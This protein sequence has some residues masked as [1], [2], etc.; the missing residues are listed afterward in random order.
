MLP[1]LFICLQE[2]RGFPTTKA[3]LQPPNTYITCST[4]GKLT[5]NLITEWLDKVFLNEVEKTEEKKALLLHDSTPLFKNLEPTIA[6]HPG[7][8]IQMAC[9]PP[10]TTGLVQPL[11]VF[12]FRPWKVFV[13][14]ISDYVIFHDIP[15]SLM[16]RDNVIK[17][18]SL[19]HYQFSAERYESMV[20]YSFNKC[21]FNEQYDGEEFE[22]P[23]SFTFGTGATL[24]DC[25]SCISKGKEETG[26]GCCGHC[27]NTFCFEHFYG[28]DCTLD[29]HT[30][31]DGPFT[32]V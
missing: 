3:F 22:T 1:I 15:I 32:F 29:F 18:Q 25:L 19:V 13:R 2:P 6:A 8:N 26:F 12:F 16:K 24:S 31:L 17:L 28:T 11:D 7:L 10:K 4:S 14:F 9:I 20:R 5:K 23:A 21:G 30:C 27:G